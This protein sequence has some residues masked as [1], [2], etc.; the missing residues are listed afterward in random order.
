[1]LGRTYQ[2]DAL[3]SDE[4]LIGDFKAILHAHITIAANGGPTSLESMVEAAK[5]DGL[6][7][8]DLSYVKRYNLH[9]VAERNAAHAKAV[10]A[11]YPD[12]CMGCFTDMTAVYG[13]TG[14][15]MLDAHHLTAIG[16]LAENEMARFTVEDFAVLCPNCHRII[17]RL[18]DSSDLEKLQAIVRREW[19]E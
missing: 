6:G 2:A 1:M 10:K 15:E 3:P 17:H 14:A 13:E 11:H 9:R 7:K 12:I 16:H 8:A 19:A 5:A 18:V 4:E